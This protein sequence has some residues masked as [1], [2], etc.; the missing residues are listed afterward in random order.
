MKDILKDILVR[1]QLNIQNNETK[2]KKQIAVN[3]IKV[4]ILNNLKFPQNHDNGFT[5]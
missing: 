3:L 4:E 1:R 2:I 5:G